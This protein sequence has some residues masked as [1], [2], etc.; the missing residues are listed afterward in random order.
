MTDN[1]VR[2][3]KKNPNDW[4]SWLVYSD[5]LQGPLRALINIEHRLFFSPSH[6]EGN[7]YSALM[8]AREQARNDVEED[9]KKK[10]V[11]RVLDWYHGLPHDVDFNG[12]DKQRTELVKWNPFIRF[13]ETIQGD[14][15]AFSKLVPGTRR[16]VDKLWEDRLVLHELRE[17]GFDTADGA[18]YFMRDRKPYFAL[19]RERSNP[20]LKNPDEAYKQFRETRN[21]RLPEE[22][23]ESA[24]ADPETEVFDL[25]KLSLNRNSEA[26]PYLELSTENPELDS[27]NDDQ[28]RLIRRVYGKDKF[29]EVMS[30]LAKQWST[31][32]TF[33]LNLDYVREYASRGAI[34]RA[35]WL[36]NISFGAVD[37]GIYSNICLRGVLAA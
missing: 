1:I 8:K 20:L 30:M 34:G 12:N 36:Y 17:M 15:R 31:T 16:H 3:L 26:N 23:L 19:T 10:G 13:I 27:L 7:N 4:D 22:D 14:Y 11:S 37:Y 9:L 2:D 21:Y 24:L 6:L 28:R 35:S 29:Y 25:S 32:R 33:V 18:I 5:H